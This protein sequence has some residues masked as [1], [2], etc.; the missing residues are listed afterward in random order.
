M[1]DRTI[2]YI[3]GPDPEAF[4]TDSRDVV[5]TYHNYENQ[6]VLREKYHTTTESPHFVVYYN[7]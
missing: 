1:F 4:S 7:E 6:D 5:I 2:R 3:D